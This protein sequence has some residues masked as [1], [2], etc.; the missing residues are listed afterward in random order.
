[1]SLKGCK[2]SS[3]IC[4]LFFINA[5]FTKNSVFAWASKYL[6]TSSSFA[7]KKVQLAISK[8]STH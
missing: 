1:M 3:L 2:R 5:Y 7:S 4:L 8:V 6:Q